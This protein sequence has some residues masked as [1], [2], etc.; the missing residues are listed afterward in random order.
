VAPLTGKQHTDW[1]LNSCTEGIV[2]NKPL[3]VQEIVLSLGNGFPEKKQE[4]KFGNIKANLAC[5]DLPPDPRKGG[6]K[7]LAG[8]DANKNGK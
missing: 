7:T 1:K 3:F 6:T 8:F 4:F 2:A 5:L